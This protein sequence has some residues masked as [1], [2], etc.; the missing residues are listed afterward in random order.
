MTLSERFQEIVRAGF[1]GVYVV[2]H[3]PDEAIASLAKQASQ[4]SW[5]FAVWDIDAGLQCAGRPATAIDPLSAV[6]AAGAMAKPEQTAVLILRNFHRFLQ[7]V[8]VVQAVERQ[9]ARG[10]AEGVVLVALAP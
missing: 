6:R 4:H 8:D 3:E 2:T 1:A 7:G 9:L 10:K 5:A